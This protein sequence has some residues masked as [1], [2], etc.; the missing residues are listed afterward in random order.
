MRMTFLAGVALAAALAAPG[1]AYAQDAPPVEQAPGDTYII[2][3][4]EDEP[5]RVYDP[6]IGMNRRLYSVHEAVDRTLLEPAARGYQVLPDPVR[7]RVSNVLRH[8]R[9]PQI[10]ANDILQG[11][12]SRAGTT[13][14]RFVIN[15]TVGVLGIFDPATSMGFERHTEDFGQTLAVWG[16]PPGPYV[17]VPVFGPTNVRDGFGAVVNLA[18][19]PLNYIEFDYDTEFTVARATLSALAAR[20][21]VLGAVETLRETSDDPYITLRTSYHLLR[22]SAI[23][24]GP[25]DV[26]D[27]PSFDETLEEPGVTLEEAP[28]VPEEP[29]GASVEPQAEPVPPSM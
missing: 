22:E 3:D 10:F 8:L 5:G 2:L 21:S 23:R 12:F 7:R 11:E 24:N 28:V 29:G 17:F 27:L 1:G 15:T 6:W 16:V 13:A 14:S 20:E 19:D 9:S 25:T 4:P 18:L 26:Q